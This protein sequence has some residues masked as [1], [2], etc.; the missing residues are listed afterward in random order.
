MD[1]AHTGLAEWLNVYEAALK[2]LGLDVNQRAPKNSMSGEDMKKL[3]ELVQV[4]IASKEWEIGQH[5]SSAI[6]CIAIRNS[7]NFSEQ[8][9]V[10]SVC[11]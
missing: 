10:V 9:Y 6:L 2:E 7:D 3:D 4:R 1:K 8:Y 5:R 11:F